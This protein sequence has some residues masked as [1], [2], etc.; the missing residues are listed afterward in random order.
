MATDLINYNPIYVATPTE[1]RPKTLVTS[2]EWNAMWATTVLQTNDTAETLHNLLKKLASETWSVNGAAYLKAP[3]LADSNSDNVAGQLAWL[4]GYLDTHKNSADHDSRYFL[5][6]DSDLRYALR[7]EVNNLVLGQI[8]NGSITP[9][10][11][12][13]D[14]VLQGDFDALAGTVSGHTTSLS[15]INN[16]FVT[17]PVANKLLKLNANGKYAAD[18][19]DKV[20]ITA[21]ADGQA[22]GDIYVDTQIACNKLS[23]LYLAADGYRPAVASSEATLPCTGMA[24][25][26]NFDTSAHPILRRGFIKCNTW[27]YPKGQLLYLSPSVAGAWRPTMPENTGDRIQILG[28]AIAPNVVYFNPQYMW[29]EL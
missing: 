2:D 9:E 12:N 16:L 29:I 14:T 8:P 3:A 21:M 17:T 28:Q 13:F 5:R 6:A 20:D 15:N 26:T 10:K 4:K 18:I 22:I 1:H 23:P 24:L 7:T 19:L 11:L 25:E 27:T